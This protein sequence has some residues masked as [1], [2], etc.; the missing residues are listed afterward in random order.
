MVGG[1]GLR[2]PVSTAVVGGSLS[3]KYAGVAAVPRDDPVR[4]RVP[5]SQRPGRRRRDG[6]PPG[7]IQPD[8]TCGFVIYGT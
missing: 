1:T 4:Q 5:R 6:A 8:V 7:W 3:L 2:R